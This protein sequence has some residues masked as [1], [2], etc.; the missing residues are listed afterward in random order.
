MQVFKE[1]ISNDSVG[2][3]ALPERRQDAKTPIGSTEIRVSSQTLH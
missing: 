3:L 1:D 2:H